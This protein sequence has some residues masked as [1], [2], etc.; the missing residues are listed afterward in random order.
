MI[1]SKD[2]ISIEITKNDLKKLDI[3]K[4][5][6]EDVLFYMNILDEKGYGYKLEYNY[7]KRISMIIKDNPAIK[8]WLYVGENGDYSK[9]I[10]LKD[11]KLINKLN[12]KDYYI[13]RFGDIVLSGELPYMKELL[14]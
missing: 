2:I 10:E 13:G 6:L 4:E 8:G 7:I 3:S 12:E 11:S 9:H 14:Q 1:K 5:H